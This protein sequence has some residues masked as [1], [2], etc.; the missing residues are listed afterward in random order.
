MKTHPEPEARGGSREE[1]PKPKARA[2][3]LEEHPEEGWLL[4]CRRA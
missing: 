1:L 4:R 3:G 2:R